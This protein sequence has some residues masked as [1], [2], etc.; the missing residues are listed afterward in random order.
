MAAGKLKIKQDLDD[1]TGPRRTSSSNED[2]IHHE[3]TRRPIDNGETS[4]AKDQHC[5]SNLQVINK[6]LSQKL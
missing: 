3:I 1:E 4:E 5:Q 6:L 2:R